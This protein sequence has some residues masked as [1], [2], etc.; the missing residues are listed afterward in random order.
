MSFESRKSV[1]GVPTGRW[2]AVPEG[3]EGEGLAP[4]QTNRRYSETGKLPRITS[5]ATYLVADQSRLEVTVAKSKR[6]GKHS[7][8]MARV[9]LEIPENSKGRIKV[10]TGFPKRSTIFRST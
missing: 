5:V 10:H 4:A 8:R 7:W 9:G 3:R 2:Q 1:L 6:T